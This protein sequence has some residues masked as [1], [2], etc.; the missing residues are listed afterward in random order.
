[1]R[2]VEV[3][4][5]VVRELEVGGDGAP[6]VG[7]DLVRVEE[8]LKLATTNAEGGWIRWRAAGSMVGPPPVV[9][10]GPARFPTA[11]PRPARLNPTTGRLDPV[12]GRQIK[13]A[14][15]LQRV[16]RATLLLRRATAT[17][18]RGWAW[19]AYPRVFFVFSILLTVAGNWSSR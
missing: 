9:D 8:E 1:L 11:D 14:A 15:L 18:A 2:E 16:R 7:G 6:M 12:V 13:R 5:V 10:L 17:V 19:R 3:S 4:V